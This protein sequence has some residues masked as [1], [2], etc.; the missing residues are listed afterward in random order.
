LRNPQSSVKVESR[1]S[2]GKVSA[3]WMHLPL[4][5]REV[6]FGRSEEYEALTTGDGDAQSHSLVDILSQLRTPMR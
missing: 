2:D 5:K 6:I 4:R 1:A 3:F